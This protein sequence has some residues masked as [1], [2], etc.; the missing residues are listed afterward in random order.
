MAPAR[1]AD[2]SLQPD[3]AKFPSGMAALGDAL[4]ALGLKFGIYTA[5]GNR[6]CQKPAG[7]L[8]PTTAA[9]CRRSPTGG[10]RLREGGR[11]RGAADVGR[12]TQDTVTE[13]FYHFGQC[14]G[15]TWP[16]AVYSQELP[17]MYIGQPGFQKDVQASSGFAGMWRV[18]PDEGPVTQ[19]NA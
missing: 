8:E 7:Q 16:G 2:G 17:V 18:A 4:H 1:A 5:I 9:T 14:S 6:T 12:E 19:A 3:L 13:D 10:V 11:V 15:S